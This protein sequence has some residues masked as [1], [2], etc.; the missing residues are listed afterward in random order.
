MSRGGWNKGLT[1]YTDP[2]IAKLAESVKIS[3]NRPKVKEKHSQ[4]TKQQWKDG[5]H[6]DQFTPDVRDRIS[7][8][9]SIVQNRPELKDMHTQTIRK[10]P[11]TNTPNEILVQDYLKSID[12]PFEVNKW[13]Q[14]DVKHHHTRPDIFIKPNICIYIDGKYWHNLPGRQE[15]DNR[16]TRTLHDR[17]YQVLRFWGHDL[18]ENPQKFQRAI[19][20][21]LLS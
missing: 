15:M 10:M 18:R 19:Q 6:D 12:V 4:I 17:G 14:F 1:K 11:T 8:I 9:Q 20:E 2:R 5:V 16:I 21:M 3:M 7:I 13:I